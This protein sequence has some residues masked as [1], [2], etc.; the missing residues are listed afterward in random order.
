MDTDKTRELLNNTFCEL[1]FE[2]GSLSKE[3]TKQLSNV[4]ET[5]MTGLKGEWS[6]PYEKIT[7]KIYSMS[8]E[9]IL[10]IEKDVKE[11][12]DTVKLEKADPQDFIKIKNDTLRNINL[13]VQQRQYIDKTLSDAEK[14]LNTVKDI[15]DKIY[16]DFITILGIFT[17]I[18]FA[19][20]GGLQ[21]LGN[22]FGKTLSTVNSNRGIGNAI[23]LAG[24]YILAIYIILC[25]L[26][27][28]LQKLQNRTFIILQNKAGLFI[29]S[30]VLIILF[31]VV[32]QA[33]YSWFS[34]LI[35]LGIFISVLF[36]CRIVLFDWKKHKWEKIRLNIFDKDNDLKK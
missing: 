18:T 8:P 9:K 21:L 33:V 23:I 28:G 17:A 34:V 13:A 22:I 19:T 3:E 14:G 35:L 15:K 31:G 5:A 10:D 32:Y 29:A 16:T 20:F 24:F 26:F 30:S 7:H 11:K 25:A 27:G 6:I 2:E 12:L 36:I 4:I 1:L